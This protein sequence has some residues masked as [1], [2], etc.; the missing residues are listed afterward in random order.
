[1]SR[2]LHASPLAVENGFTSPNGIHYPKLPDVLDALYK[3]LP[4]EWEVDFDAGDPYFI[5]PGG[6]SVVWDKPGAPSGFVV[7]PMR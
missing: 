7:N 2:A 3:D 4:S 6:S 1:M 5:A